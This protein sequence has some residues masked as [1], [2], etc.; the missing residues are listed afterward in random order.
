MKVEQCHSKALLNFKDENLWN[1]HWC[2]IRTHHNYPLQKYTFI[3]KLSRK[4]SLAI[5]HEIDCSFEMRYC[6]VPLYRYIKGKYS[7][8]HPPLFITS[9]LKKGGFP[10]AFFCPRKLDPPQASLI[11]NNNIGLTVRHSSHKYSEQCDGKG[12]FWRLVRT[13][14]NYPLKNT[15]LNS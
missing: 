12:N 3:K 6:G 9:Y 13:N 10:Y 11:E 4:A 15:N 8:L 1:S 7:L 5:R 14:H 2:L